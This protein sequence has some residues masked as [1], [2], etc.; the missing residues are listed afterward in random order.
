[1]TRKN[2]KKIFFNI[3]VADTAR[4]GRFIAQ[5]EE[6]TIFFPNGIPEE[7]VDVEVRNRRDR[8]PEGVI[9]HFY[10][11]SL[12]RCVPVCK[13]F[14]ICGGCPW[15]HISYDHQ[16]FLKRTFIEKIFRKAGIEC[17][18]SSVI[19]SK[20]VLFYRNKL[21]YSFSDTRWFYKDE[22]KVVCMKDRLALGFHPSEKPNK[23]LDISTCYMMGEFSDK[24]CSVIKTFTTDRNYSYFSLKTR[25]GF[26]RNL[27]IRAS[28]AGSLMLIIG[29]GEN[30]PEHIDEL[31]C[32]IENKFPEITCLGYRIY[33]DDSDKFNNPEILIYNNKNSFFENI[34]ALK[35]RISPDVFLQPNI[36]QAASLYE[37]IKDFAGFTGKEIVYDLYCGAGTI[38]CFIAKKVKRVV[39]LEYSKEAIEDA[40]YNAEINCVSNAE[41][42]E[43]DI[44]KTFSPDFVKQHGSPDIIILDPPRSG[45]W[46]ETLKNIIFTAPEKIIY[47]SCNPVSQVKDIVQL[48]HVYSIEKIQAFDM[49]PQTH[50]VENVVLMQKLK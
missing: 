8:F 47:V 50:H 29:F 49:F 13:N 23:V 9:S 45:V 26:L 36:L 35:F 21:E 43:C 38:S 14:D 33:T 42:I 11:T 40:K 37:W 16:L 19:P 30:F 6:K 28:V 22:G 20:K 12:H 15:M 24:I 18:I 39:G 27:V 46:K 34:G 44:G 5:S 41:F 31:M 7:I 1:M 25:K 2:F 48:L 3:V 4:D 10:K 17:E 32:F